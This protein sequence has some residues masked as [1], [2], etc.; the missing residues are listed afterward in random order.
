MYFFIYIWNELKL[1]GFSA[2]NMIKK[3]TGFS[4]NLIVIMFIVIF[5][6]R[7][8]SGEFMNFYNY[9][10]F[11]FKVRSGFL[12]LPFPDNI[13]MIFM[14]VY[15]FNIIQSFQSPIEDKNSKYRFVIAIWG[16]V[17]LFYFVNRSHPGNLLAVSLPFFLS[18][19]CLIDYAFSYCREKMSESEPE[20]L[21]NKMA[22]RE[23]LPILLPNS[24]EL[25]RLSL[26]SVLIMPF[27]IMSLI[28][29]VKFVPLMISNFQSPKSY[30]QMSALASL[31]ERVDTLEKQLNRPSILLSG[32]FESYYYLH[33]NRKVLFYPE[34][35]SILSGDNYSF[36]P[37]FIDALNKFNPI[38]TLCPINIGLPFIK[39]N[40]HDTF[41]QL[42]YE[43]NYKLL[44]SQKS[45]DS[46][47]QGSC[48]IYVKD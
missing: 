22:F 42:L 26:V 37:R 31:S 1:D 46:T 45:I 21:Q 8:L 30:S 28:A 6:F 48:D 3:L 40:L 43:N 2:K 44:E 20:L 25:L 16:I 9:I 10:Y 27:I 13:W 12:G 34:T 14:V 38:V 7:I 11:T 18:Y 35:T 33:K 36:Q 47:I 4:I 19:G 39:E 41:L 29:C 24:F 5:G 23:F 15:G 32:L 17:S